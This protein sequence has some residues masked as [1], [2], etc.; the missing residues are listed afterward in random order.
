MLEVEFK[1]SNHVS[2]LGYES[3]SA[4]AGCC[5]SRNA[6]P[7]CLHAP[8]MDAVLVCIKVGSLKASGPE[9]LEPLG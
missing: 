7:Q 6:F 9:W 4:E 8:G 2:M 1:T 3:R 5:P